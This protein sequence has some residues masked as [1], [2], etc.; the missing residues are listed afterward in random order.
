[1]DTSTGSVDD[2]TH[3]QAEPSE[4]DMQQFAQQLRSA[5]AEGVLVDVF[6][7]LLS[8]AQIKLGR[9]DARLFIDLCASML[10]QVGGQLSEGVRGQVEAALGQ[11][12]LGQVSAE[13]EAAKRRETRPNDPAGP[14][15]PDTTAAEAPTTTADPSSA[16]ASPL[17]TP[18]H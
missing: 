8:T 17:W 7:T 15:S 18:G 9:P 10:E 3:D 12:R 6:S 13:T 16:P 2:T 1:M 4:H 14:A 11:L 5:P